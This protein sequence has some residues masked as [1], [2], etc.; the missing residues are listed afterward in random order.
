MYRYTFFFFDLFPLWPALEGAGEEAVEE[1]PGE[2]GQN[3]DIEGEE[4]YEAADDAGAP[5]REEE[6]VGD[7]ES[8]DLEETPRTENPKT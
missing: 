8:A 3:V 1:E 6:H 4:V 7:E 5:I 2:S